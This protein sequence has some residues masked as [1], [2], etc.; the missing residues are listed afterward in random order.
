M[1]EFAEKLIERLE[2]ERNYNEKMMLDSHDCF[3]QSV[4]GTQMNTYEKTI[5]IV[6]QLA[7]EYNQDSTKNN[8]GWIPCEE[9]YPDTEK[10]ILLSFENFSLPLVGRYE[11]DENGGAFY[12]GDEMES[13]VSQDMIV[14]AW[15][16]LPSPYKLT[17]QNQQT[18]YE[19]IRSMSVEELADKILASDICSNIDFCQEFPNCQNLMEKGEEILDEMCKKCLIQWLNS[20]E[21][22]EC[23]K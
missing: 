12:I 19:R 8:Q 9:K 16:P 10:Y 13:C 15:Q 6:K 21:K 23:E 20:P 18:R 3:H 1:K 5:N 2:E 11:E 4:Y 17:E 14:N 7:E 22:K